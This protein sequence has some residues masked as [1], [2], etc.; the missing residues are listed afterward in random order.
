M[1][2]KIISLIGLLAIGAPAWSAEAPVTPVEVTFVASENFT[3]VK[4]DAL[5]TGR[6]RDF[7]L[8]QL[9]E[10]IQS[11]GPRYLGE[12]Q[13]LEIKVTNVDLAGEFEP[14]RGS[15]FDTVRIMRDIYPPRMMLEFRL[16]DSQGRVVA[17]GSRQLQEL[18]YLELLSVRTDD[19]L[20]YDK[21][22]INNWFRREFV[23][24]S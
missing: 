24:A 18:S 10:Y 23:R 16:F 9:K 14:W 3:D 17:E 20:R 22:M 21:E 13:R 6:G 1:K 11:R 8:A 12:A 7:L 4:D 15:G 19:R 2:I 5:D